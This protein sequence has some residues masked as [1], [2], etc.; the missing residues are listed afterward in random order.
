M[1][2]RI[3]ETGEAVLGAFSSETLTGKKQWTYDRYQEENHSSAA[4][5]K[6]TTSG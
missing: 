4:A 1:L 3:Q 2:I 6:P 5:F